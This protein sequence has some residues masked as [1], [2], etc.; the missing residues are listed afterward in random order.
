[1]RVLYLTS[2][3]SDVD[4]AQREIDKSATGIVLEP[5]ASARDVAARLEGGG[6]VDAIVVDAGG[7][8]E[9]LSAISELRA[10]SGV[11]IVALVR[12]ASGDARAEA[13]LAGADEVAPRRP[14]T[15][16]AL[17]EAIRLASRRSY[18]APEPTVTLRLG[19]IGD[20][21]SAQ[22]ALSAYPHIVVESVGCDAA[23]GEPSLPSDARVWPDAFA[24]DET[25]G[26][27]QVLHAVGTLADRASGHPV[28]V[29]TG[30]GPARE[31]TYRRRGATAAGPPGALDTLVRHCE[32]SVIRERARREIEGLRARELRLRT[33]VETLPHGVLRIARDGSLL[34]VNLSGLA[35]FGA[36]RPQQVVGKNLVALA[37]PASRTAVATLLASVCGGEPAQATLTVTGVDGEGRRVDLRGTPFR[38]EGLGTEVLAA[39]HL[40]PVSASPAGSLAPDTAPASMH[41]ALDALRA[42][43]DG[44]LA[45]SAE[46]SEDVGAWRVK[47][48]ALSEELDERR[49]VAEAAAEAQRLADEEAARLASEL[50]AA[51]ERWESDRAAFEQRLRDAEDQQAREAVDAA[52]RALRLQ[53]LEEEHRAEVEVLRAALAAATAQAEAAAALPPEAQAVQGRDLAVAEARVGQLAATLEAAQSH[54]RRLESALDDLRAEVDAT[55]AREADATARVAELEAVLAGQQT[56]V[57]A[58]RLREAEAGAR[59]TALEATLAERQREVDAQLR[60]FHEAADVLAARG[61]E[62]ADARDHAQRLEDALEAVGH[63]KQRLEQAIAELRAEADAARTLETEGVSRVVELEA[64]LARQQGEADER[65]RGLREE[66]DA[67]RAQLEVAER[68]KQG[69]EQAMAD[70]RA[71]ADE[72]ARGLRDEADAVR[73]QLEAA[74]AESGAR[75][76]HLLS[77]LERDR[78]ALA[79]AQHEVEHLREAIRTLEGTVVTVTAARAAADARARELASTHHQ[80]EEAY[81]RVVGDVERLRTDAV[82]AA[83][84]AESMARS[85]T[86]W[87]DRAAALEQSLAAA[88]A[89]AEGVRHELAQV[90]RAR[91]DAHDAVLRLEARLAQVD[92]QQAEQDGALQVERDRVEGLQTMLQAERDRAVGIERELEAIRLGRNEVVDELARLRAALD[93]ALGRRAEVERLHQAERERAD[94]LVAEVRASADARNAS[95]EELARVRV[96]AD[97][98][99]RRAEALQADLDQERA[100]LTR[101]AAD[102]VALAGARDGLTSEVDRLHRLVTGA[103]SRRADTEAEFRRLTERHEGLSADHEHL[104]ASLAEAQRQLDEAKQR[105]VGAENE[106]ETLRQGLRQAETAAALAAARQNEERALVERAL[107]D[108][109]ARLAAIDQEYRAAH[110]ALERRLRQA[111]ERETLLLSSAPFGLATA[112]A[113]GVLISCNDVFARWCGASSAGDLM[114]RQPSTL[115]VSLAVPLAEFAEGQVPRVEACVEQADG[116]LVWLEGVATPVTSEAAL[117]AWRWTFADVTDRH[118]RLRQARQLRR[119]EA[120]AALASSASHDLGGLMHSMRDAVDALAA[121]GGPE[122][123][124]VAARAAVAKATALSHQLASFAQKQA[125]PVQ[126]VDLARLTSDLAPTLR[127]LLGGDVGLETD[128]GVP[129]HLSAD[130]DELEQIVAALVLAGRDALPVGGTI[131]LA[132][133]SRLVPASGDQ[134]MQRVG[135]L[136]CT[137]TGFGVRQAAPATSAS[138]AVAQQ[139]GYLRLDHGPGRHMAFE[140]V[141]PLVQAAA[142]SPRGP[143]A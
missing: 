83:E 57:D 12:Q 66:A 77:E 131:T 78:T 100:R 38:R 122:A 82:V 64:V 103:E 112:S 15:P 110:E 21:P 115:P 31:A 61:R 106:R 93:E 22:R 23:T 6:P 56:D 132:V 109:R 25:I 7:T 129:V 14:A 91:D 46:A 85:T 94:G 134:P 48:E 107:E 1:M 102:L 74:A 17:V 75:V 138:E 9:P 20:L 97:E 130:S 126:V 124:T 18:P 52:R 123:V 136:R 27:P 114:A 116:R 41:V 87:Q 16:D 125:R 141:W 90:A 58:L 50:A 142:T 37:E 47:V 49:A 53:Q 135:V 67:V 59:V 81:Q 29:V 30:A 80:L 34:A 69:L 119:L 24:L 113:H 99:A 95:I 89:E 40:A 28:F 105:L 44:A 10:K 143:G 33:V 63:E 133:E 36:S 104:R 60:A 8:P 11:T 76:H 71:E 70:L 120:L 32:Q 108:A 51:R 73:A 86:Q 79:S 55:R 2:H 39:V 62:L 140:V 35:I 117:S 118:L 127:R 19:W 26:A 92:R 111:E 13:L 137:A 121:S 45:R 65:A 3:L 43:V 96:L 68:E 42:E 98:A 72:R 54:G 101:Q 84:R 128:T 139:A 4:V 5:C 88:S